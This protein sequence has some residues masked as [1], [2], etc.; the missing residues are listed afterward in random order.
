MTYLWNF[1]DGGVTSTI[2]KPTKIYAQ[3]GPNGGF[4]TVTLTVSNSA[5]SNQTSAQVRVGSMTG[6]WV[7]AYSGGWTYTMTITQSGL[8]LSGTLS[9]SR[10]PGRTGP[11]SG[12]VA[13]PRTVTIDRAYSVNAA[14]DIGMRNPSGSISTAATSFSGTL[15][16]VEL[17]AAGVAA[18][19]T[20]R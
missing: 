19:F 2:Q 10:F 16:G 7:F 4:Y 6:Q 12:S 11:L 3:G 18:T 5:G 1:G 14:Q 15:R 8:S 20:L 9:D 13:A 17:P